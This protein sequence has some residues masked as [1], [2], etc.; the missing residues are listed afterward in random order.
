MCGSTGV[1]DLG[2]DGANILDVDLQPPTN[3]GQE[4]G[5]EDIGAAGE[6]VEQLAGFN[7]NL[8]IN[9]PLFY[10]LIIIFI[11]FFTL[12]CVGVTA[13]DFSG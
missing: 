2:V 4:V 12:F 8:T 1:D 11:S 9:L 5:E 10:F 13:F 7:C 6:L 3:A